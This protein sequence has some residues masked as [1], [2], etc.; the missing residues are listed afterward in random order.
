LHITLTSQDR[1]TPRQLFEFGQPEGALGR[2]FEEGK[3]RRFTDIA[4]A[5]FLVHIVIAGEKSRSAR[6]RDVAA[7]RPEDAERV[8]LTEGRSR[9]PPR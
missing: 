3:E 2:A 7:D 5:M 6:R 4:Q 1:Q 8:L 9:P